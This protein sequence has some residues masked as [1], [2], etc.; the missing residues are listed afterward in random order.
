MSNIIKT[1]PVKLDLQRVGAQAQALPILVEGDTG[2]V[3][4]IT[5]TDGGAPLD[6]SDASRVVCVFS[7]TSDG[8]TVEQDTGDA[9]VTMEDIGI[10]I[11]G[12]PVTDDTAVVDQNDEETVITVPITLSATVDAAVFREAYPDNGQY[13]FTFKA[14]GWQLGD[15]SVIISGDD[16][17]IITVALKA[18]S[19]G[20]GTNNA[21]V[22]IYSGADTLVT[23]ANFNF[24]GRK[25]IMNDETIRSEQKYPV[26]TQLLST[27]QRLYNS[28]IRWIGVTASAQRTDG[29]AGVTLS[30]VDGHQHFAFDI[31]SDVSIGATAPTGQQ[32]IWLKPDGVGYVLYYNVNGTWTGVTTIKGTGISGAVL[33]PDYTL[34]LT[35]DDGTSYTTPSIKGDKGDLTSLVST[36][37]AYAVSDTASKPADTDFSPSASPVQGKY[38][39][40]RTT[41]TF[42]NG[43]TPS[44]YACAYVGE[45]G[46][47][48]VDSVNG[49][50]GAVVLD[51]DDV[52]A[53]PDS[54]EVNGY[55]LD[56][57]ISLDASDVGAI[58]SNKLPS[59]ITVTL[60]AAN[61]SSKAQTISNAAFVTSGF[62][63]QVSPDP[64]D[65]TAYGESQI[66]ADNVTVSGQMTFHCEDEPASDLDVVILKVGV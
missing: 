26:L 47:G 65:F 33:N 12:T 4:E 28:V 63:Y 51:A 64:S 29:A 46:H 66:Y 23:S 38:Y 30:E 22:Q 43:M 32:S 3:F 62:A 21:E 18:A 54:R 42:D 1:I 37:Y 2:N 15:N 40:V 59:V 6:L 17:N 60:L 48:N 56:A 49:Q 14:A 41:F 58:P 8:S 45:D 31:P 55:S 44:A 5:M 25:G 39:W 52:G 35:F 7:K 53:V 24:R 20:A 10:E 50:T 19:Y 27:V 13:V 57:D 9:L 61:W 16:S 11:S 34:T 36:S